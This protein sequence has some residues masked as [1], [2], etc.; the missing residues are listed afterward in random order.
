RVQTV[1]GRADPVGVDR[2]DRLGI[3]LST[4]LEQ[5]S[6]R[7]GLPLLDGLGRNLVLVSVGQPGRAGDD[8]HHL[9]G[10]PPEVL[11]RLLV[12]DLVQL[13]EPPESGETRRLRLQVGR[14][15]A[16]DAHRIEGLGKRHARLDVVVHEQAPHVLVRVLADQRLDVDAAVAERSPL[17]V[18]LHDLG[19]DRDDALETGLEVVA[20]HTL[21]SSSSISRPAPRSRAARSTSAAAA[22]SWTATPT[23]LY[24]VI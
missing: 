11:A 23:D 18:G 17:A 2:L 3:G 9:A 21:I 20:A 24:R 10:D 19:L 4:P 7:R 1:L 13:A 14:C 6:L 5:E 16:G 8:R 12:G 22:R 15:T